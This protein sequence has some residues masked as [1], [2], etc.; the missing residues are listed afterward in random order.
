MQNPFIPN[1]LS[2]LFFEAV[3]EQSQPRMAK[4]L[5]NQCGQGFGGQELANCLLDRNGW[6]YENV[7]RPG[8]KLT[9][10][11]KISLRRK[12]EIDE[13]RYTSQIANTQQWLQMRMKRIKEHRAKKQNSHT[14]T[15]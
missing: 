3:Q 13:K 5:Y 1:T 12:S 7:S 2:Y 10:N 8:K 11:D 6:L 9:L 14:A 15:T 4:T